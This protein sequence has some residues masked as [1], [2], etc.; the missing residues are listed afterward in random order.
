MSRLSAF[1]KLIFVCLFLG[2]AALLVAGPAQ[3]EAVAQPV[4]KE[5]AR[6]GIVGL[7]KAADGSYS[8]RVSFEAPKGQMYVASWERSK[9]LWSSPAEATAA[10]NRLGDCQMSVRKAWVGKWNSFAEVKAHDTAP[11]QDRWTTPDIA[12]GLTACYADSGIGSEQVKSDFSDTHSSIDIPVEL[13]GP[14]THK[15]FVMGVTQP[16]QP[17]RGQPGCTGVDYADGSWA[18]AGC[19]FA[20]S[21]PVSFTVTVPYPPAAGMVLPGANVAD[22]SAFH[23]TVFSR[24]VTAPG[25]GGSGAQ[26]DMFTKAGLTVALALVLAI[27]IA[28]PTEL[29]ENTISKNHSR[30]AAF[31]KRLLPA[32]RYAFATGLTPAGQHSP[33]ASQPLKVRRRLPILGGV[34]RWWSFPTLL[35]G[36]VI[37]GFA[38]PKFGI[39]WMSLR[40]VIT[41][42]VAFLIVNLGGTFLTW[43][44]TR[45]HTGTEKPRLRARPFYLVLI[46]AT[47]IFARV[48]TVEPALVFGTLLAIDYGIRL[49]RARSAWV[50]IVGT[51]YATVLGLG[52]WVGYTAIAQFKLADVGNLAEI[53][54]QYT[55]QVYTAIS[56]TQT[57]LGELASTICIQALTT[58]PIALLPLAFLSGSALWQWKKWVWVVTY[59]A[60]LA[61]YSFVLVP[62]PTSWKEISQSL[63]LWVGI[64]VSYVILAVGLW[65][66]FRITTK[67]DPS[68]SDAPSRPETSGTAAPEET[69]E[70]GTATVPAEVAATFAADDECVEAPPSVEGTVQESVFEE[71]AVANTGPDSK[72]AAPIAEN[73]AAQPPAATTDAEPSSGSAEH[74]VI[75]EPSA[76]HP[77]VV[78]EEPDDVDGKMPLAIPSR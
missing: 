67:A 32:G 18:G 17:A 58:V 46:L 55:F 75:P 6:S 50:T 71:G 53:D 49:S 35:A 39:N 12:K 73:A 14:G 30:I 77:E 74:G 63:A 43:L 52:A 9:G 62:M 56:F 65:A 24:L 23:S 68:V 16:D 31:I 11:Q 25:F 21:E 37:A 61:A 40:L 1:L 8:W 72:A 27:L 47:V 26:D 3:A 64:F 78:P 15:L 48:V 36:A 22:G 19:Q 41:I 70:T 7:N 38:E 59:A 57:A 54:N 13:I 29:V 66:Y 20:T 76:N 42:F 69:T 34:S 5:P 2:S 10:L 60:G 51:V 4:I 45:R 28:L 44:L 33:S